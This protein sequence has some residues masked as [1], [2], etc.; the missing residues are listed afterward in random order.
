M[1]WFSGIY[2]PR[3]AVHDEAGK[4]I[5]TGR[6]AAVVRLIFIRWKDRS[7][8]IPRSSGP[9]SL[10]VP[11][12]INVL[13]VRLGSLPRENVI[14]VSPSIVVLSK[15]PLDL[16]YRTLRKPD[17][18]LPAPPLTIVDHVHSKFPEERSG[19]GWF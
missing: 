4:P 1:R 17:R 15:D 2:Q 8:L 19:V 14:P 9:S 11:R 16:K 10:T 18:Y 13:S 5:A 6:F 3:T 12:H 7:L